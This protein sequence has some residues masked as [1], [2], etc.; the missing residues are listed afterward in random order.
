MYVSVYVY[1]YVNVYVCINIYIYMYTCIF[2]IILR[3]G[4]FV[5]VVSVICVHSVDY[6]FIILLQLQF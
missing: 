4:L 6:I 2:Y 3:S 1:V 5:S